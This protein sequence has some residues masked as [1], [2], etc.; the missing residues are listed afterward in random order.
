MDAD[1]RD[2]IVRSLEE[3]RP[4]VVERAWDF[5]TQQPLPEQAPHAPQHHAVQQQPEQSQQA[6]ATQQASVTQ[7][8]QG[9]P[10]PGRDKTPQAPHSSKS[11]SAL[12]QEADNLSEDAI[13]VM[14]RICRFPEE[15]ISERCLHLLI[16]RNLEWRSR[17]ALRK[18]G[19]LESAGKVGKWEFFKPTDRGTE[20][21]LTRGIALPR[22]KSGI[23]HYAIVRRV[24][25]SLGTAVAGLRF[26]TQTINGIQP[27]HIAVMKDS[28]LIPIQVSVTNTAD[29]EARCLFKLSEGPNVAAVLMVSAERHKAQAIASKLRAMGASSKIVLLPAEEIIAEKAFD[30][31]A[32]IELL[33]IARS[34]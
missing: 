17:R 12:Q 5:L 8:T 26:C 27:D 25:K 3:L 10:A 15:L 1:L 9:P 11:A 21:A 19:L 24:M 22:P 14:D 4:F 31:P 29:Y 16:D 20:W 32:H 34:K 30:W 6:P 7:V 23:L 28:V 13:L 2:V 33:K 18:Q